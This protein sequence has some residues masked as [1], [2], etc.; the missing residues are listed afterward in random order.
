MGRQRPE[1]RK[2]RQFERKF[3]RFKLAGIHLGTIEDSPNNVTNDSYKAAGNNQL[4]TQLSLSK[5]AVNGKNSRRT[6]N[7][8]KNMT[9]V[10]VQGHA[11]MDC[12]VEATRRAKVE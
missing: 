7:N 4:S 12:L 3:E 1:A 5:T 11:N 8:G 6:S 10:V 9:H 2:P